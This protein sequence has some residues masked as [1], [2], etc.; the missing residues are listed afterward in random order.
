[1]VYLPQLLC[2]V[3]LWHPE[4][5]CLTPCLLFHSTDEN[6]NKLQKVLKKVYHYMNVLLSKY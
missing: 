2:F 3:L 1:M 5:C 6:T 4:E